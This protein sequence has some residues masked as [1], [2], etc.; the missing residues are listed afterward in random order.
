MMIGGC[1]RVVRVQHVAMVPLPWTINWLHRL[2]NDGG[3]VLVLHVV[4]HHSCHCCQGCLVFLILV[5]IDDLVVVVVAIV[6]A[7]TILIVL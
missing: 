2:D 5:V 7:V 3:L 1:L 4:V 6:V